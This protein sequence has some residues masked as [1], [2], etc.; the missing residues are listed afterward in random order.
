MVFAFISDYRKCLSQINTQRLFL[1]QQVGSI[2]SDDGQSVDDTKQL[3]VVNTFYFGCD[4]ICSSNSRNVTY[5]I[6]RTHDNL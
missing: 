2:C 1:Y 4:E 5:H 6:K 3:F